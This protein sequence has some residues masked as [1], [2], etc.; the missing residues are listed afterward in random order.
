MCDWDDILMKNKL[1][2]NLKY[3]KDK[4]IDFCHSD[5]TTINE[6]NNIISLSWIKEAHFNINIKKYYKLIYSWNATWT[7]IFFSKKIWDSLKID[8]FPS[9]FAQDWWALLYASIKQYNIWF[10]KKSLI[11]YRR[12]ESSISIWFFKNKKNNTD[13][14]KWRNRIFTWEITCCSYIIENNIFIKNEQ[15]KRC[16]KH[17]YI[18]NLFINFINWKKIIMPFELFKTIFNT[19]EYEHYYRIFI[20]QARKILTIFSKS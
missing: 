14:L 8:W 12:C 9:T 3:C 11:Y 2:E 17:I 15:K 18:N 20:I 1:E 4:L 13:I 10:I 19:F 6:N 7:S 16:S 5:L